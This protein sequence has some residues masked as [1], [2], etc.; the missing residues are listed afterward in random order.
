MP[1]TTLETKP[2]PA[3]TQPQRS[4]N[5]GAD[6]PDDIEVLNAR[7][8]NRG[9][10][11]REIGRRPGSRGRAEG[12]QQVTGVMDTIIVRRVQLRS[13]AEYEVI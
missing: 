1:G 13:R 12:R 11:R 4:D 10:S 7:L 2:K 8:G 6:E 5:V 9:R 3:V